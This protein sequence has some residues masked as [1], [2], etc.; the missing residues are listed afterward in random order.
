MPRCSRCRNLGQLHYTRC[1]DEYLCE[2]CQQQAV[3]ELEQLRTT[4]EDE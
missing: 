2:T 4:E 3:E 1:V